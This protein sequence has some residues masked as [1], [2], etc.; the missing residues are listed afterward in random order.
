MVWLLLLLTGAGSLQAQP[1]LS[2]SGGHLTYDGKVALP[3]GQGDWLMVVKS[4]ADYEAESDW[5]QPYG[6]N[7]TRVKLINT[8]VPDSEDP[9]F[10]WLRLQSGQFDLNQFSQPFW[11]RLRGFLEH[12][13]RNGR[14]VLLQVFDEVGLERGSNRWSNNPFHPGKNGNGLGLP[15]GDAVPEFYGTGN[16]ALLQVQKNYVQKLIAET[17]GFGNIIYEIGNEFTGPVDWLDTIIAEFTAYEQQNGID[18]V[19]T[20]MSCGESLLEHEKNHPGIDVLDVW[21]APTSMRFLSLEQTRD[22]F[23]GLFGTKPVLAGRIGPEPDW[24]DREN[25]DRV[26]ARNLFW[27]IFFSGGAGA[28]TKEDDTEL[29]SVFGPP[30]YNEDTLWE[31]FL[32]GF[33]SFVESAGDLTGLQPAPGVVENS[34]VAFNLSLKADSGLTLVYLQDGFGSSGGS[35][36]VN[37]LQDGHVSVSLFSPATGFFTASYRRTV[38]NGRVVVPVPAFPSD[39]AVVIDPSGL[40]PR[41]WPREFFRESPVKMD[42][43]VV[44]IA[45]IDPDE[46]GHRNYQGRI[47]LND[48]IFDRIP[49]HLINFEVNRKSFIETYRLSSLDFVPGYY[50]VLTEVTDRD[51]KRGCCV[52]RFRIEAP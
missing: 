42:A 6:A 43:T 38:A 25:S 13:E 41:I 51:G 7:F 24:T 10:P 2:T 28:C 20:N 3:F 19:L 15:T 49:V 37:G 46:D 16:P 47:H 14:F 33:H 30:L 21:H 31:E 11:D 9:V 34:P 8:L 45:G 50:R 29:R 52:V 27:T 44:R 18:L 23:L 26:R 39:F 32:A 1:R 17:A 22:R 48:V 36:R 5:Y 40:T 4:R 12:N 35:L